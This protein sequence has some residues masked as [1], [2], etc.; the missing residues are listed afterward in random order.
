LSE[1]QSQATLGVPIFSL[2]LSLKTQQ[3]FST[4]P[5]FRF[6]DWWMNTCRQQQND[7]QAM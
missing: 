2:R 7:I 1:L 3:P 4:V 5:A 6:A